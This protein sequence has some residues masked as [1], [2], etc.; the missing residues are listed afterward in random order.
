MDEEHCAIAIPYEL[1]RFEMPQINAVTTSFLYV[2]PPPAS[3]ARPRQPV[4][5]EGPRQSGNDGAKIHII[6]ELTKKNFAAAGVI[7]C[8]G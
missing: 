2:L 8:G 6:F 4:A 5:L 7:A 3:T 1:A